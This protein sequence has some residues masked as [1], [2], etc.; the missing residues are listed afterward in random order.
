[1]S[2]TED[3]E[4]ANAAEELKNFISRIERLETEKKDISGDIKEVYAE[5]KGRG[6]DSKAIKRI[7]KY[8]SMDPDKRK[9]DDAI[10][11]LY[12]ST[13]GIFEDD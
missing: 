1:M 13:L 7:I 11:Q 3:L 8:K 4:V 10:F 12:A 9:E 5:A 2:N 6:F